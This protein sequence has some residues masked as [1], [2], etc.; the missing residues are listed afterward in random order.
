MEVLD[1]VR[2][3]ELPSGRGRSLLALLT[4]HAGEPVAAERLIDELWGEH[5]PA[6]AATVVQ[7]LVSRLRKALEPDR[8]KAQRP[9]ALETVGVAYRLAIDPESVDANRFTRLLDEARGKPPEI[10]SA[11]L[12][13]ALKLWRGPA[14]ADFV[15]E[16]FAQRA[17]GALE[18]S[19][20]EAIE[21]WFEAQLGLGR[22]AQLVAGLQEAITTNPFRE[23]LRGS[24]MVALYRAGR[25]AEALD[26]YRETR[27]LLLDE[28]G[29][30]PGRPLQELEAAILRHDPA[31]EWRH[32]AEQEQRSH[33]GTT[34]WLPRERRTVTVAAV[35]VAPPPDPILDAEAVARIGAQAARAA[36][37]VLENHGARVEASLGDELIAFFGFPVA[38]EDD[39]LRAVRAVV[40][41]RTIVH[42]LD[43]APTIDGV[44]H[45]MRAGIETGDI[46][47]E[48]PGGALRDVV[49][50]PVVSAARR[51]QHVATEGEILVG[52]TA[53]RL[54]R[55]ATI[56]KPLDVAEG[57]PGRAWRVLEVVSRASGI[58]RAMD[59]PMIGRQNEV[60]QLRSAF[61]RAVR[62]GAV[63]RSI[64]VGDPGIGKSRLVKEVVASIGDDAHAITLR[65]APPG[66]GMGFFPVRQAVIEA[67]GVIG[68]RRLHERLE[69]AR[70]GK[71][72]VQEI[73]AAI[74]LRSPP[75]T[76]DELLAPMSRLLSTLAHDHPLI[77]LLDDLHWAD[78]AFLEFIE[79]VERELRAR[80]FL[81]CLSRPDL[82]EDGT[83]PSTSEVV[84]LAPL[85][86]SE[87]A[88]LVIDRGG[89]VAQGSL[90]RIVNLS[91]GNPLFAEQLLAA[92]DEG[93]V[94]TIPASLV[95]LLSM[96]LDRL[97]PAERDLLRCASVLG[98]DLD[99][100]LELVTSLLPDEARPFVER[101]LDALER[102]RLIVHVGRGR[103]RFAH[104]LIQMAAYQ[105]MT[106]EDR[107]RLHEVFAERLEEQSGRTGALTL[108]AGNHLRQAVEHRRAT[109]VL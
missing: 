72:A 63:A 44:K 49:T 76:A 33:G 83:G 6:T 23:R 101:H 12:A 104:A 81:V 52:P 65:C 55:G 68:W 58:P 11:K 37:E 100:D 2:H 73:A 15:Y 13:A 26:V 28:M 84:K 106:R 8:T 62:T 67:A 30:E 96:R 85:A 74:G 16:P 60:T 108:D 93:D 41:V 18:E 39:A 94:D 42:S 103:F 98:L 31:L 27:A 51:I 64:V 77:V 75:A 86:A 56:L 70:A 22:D 32:P 69:R 95:G 92:A 7:G 3:V 99:L 61:R 91:Q 25:Q 43:D 10:R 79:R 87:L 102:K 40:E 90:Q 105:S 88:N 48:G 59:A 9:Q 46:V 5:P 4:L 29:L 66:G 1:G 20:I 82:F 50:G 45:G 78:D 109:S 71:S 35:D 38:H 14:L 54:L 80:I 97:G 36:T 24:L 17:I 47:V 89:P 21:A 107:A 57:T 19:R 34:S 53:Q